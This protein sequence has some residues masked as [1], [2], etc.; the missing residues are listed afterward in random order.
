MGGRGESNSRI[1]IF[2]NIRGGQK[3]EFEQLLPS[4]MFLIPYRT[5]SLFRF[6]RV[7]PIIVENNAHECAGE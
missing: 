1:E 6:D 5:R 4:Q 7:T 3:G 2:E